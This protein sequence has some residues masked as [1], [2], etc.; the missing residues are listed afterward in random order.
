MELSNGDHNALQKQEVYQYPSSAKTVP[1]QKNSDRTFSTEFLDSILS[2][3][4]CSITLSDAREKV[5]RD[6]I[7][8]TII[9]SPPYWKKR[10]YELKKQIG[11]E[12]SIRKYVKTLVKI[13]NNWHIILKDSG[14]VFLNVGDSF[15]NAR[16]MRIPDKIAT[17]AEKNGWVLRD[18]IFWG[19]PNSTPHSA[20][21]RM[22]VREEY[23]LHFTKTPRFYYDI[24]EFKKRF[25]VSNIWTIKPACHKGEHLA[26]F[27]EELVERILL[28][29]CPKYVCAKC[30][31]PFIRQ[32]EKTAE[33]DESRPQAKR[34]RAIFEQ[35]SLTA[36]HIKAVQAVGISDAGKAIKFQTGAGKN[37]PE[38]RRLALEA[39]AVLGGYFREFTFAKKRT[40]GWKGCKCQAEIQPGIIYDPFI[41]TG[42]SL[43]IAYKLN[44]SGFGSDIK[45][46]NEIKKTLI[47]IV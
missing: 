14:S 12:D 47:D 18:M 39:K 28:L 35:S 46:Y 29:G 44:L 26:P 23:I 37:N 16:R 22:P 30:G 25:E 1:Q 20:Q 43:K 15:F 4:F 13:M 17:E 5:I 7:V 42:T 6:K 19:K 8:D 34:A 41:G 45:F 2:Q 27:P 21:R 10:D 32:L 11:Q 9:T 3:P 31:K 24:H 33:L 36:E 38:I 40:I